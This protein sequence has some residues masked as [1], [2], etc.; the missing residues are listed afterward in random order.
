MET[1]TLTYTHLVAALEEF[2]VAARNAY[3]DELI[4]GNKIASGRLLNS[5]EVSVEQ[6]GY[7]YDVVLHLEDYWKWVEEGRPP[8][9]LPPVSKILEWV[10][11]KPVLPKPSMTGRIP[12]PQSLA[13]A[14]SKSI[15]NK[16]VEPFPALARTVPA[17]VDQFSQKLAE[18]FAQDVADASALMIK[19]FFGQG[20]K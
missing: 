7:R 10:L 14:I 9:K 1:N 11:V 2:G 6:H 15:A 8:G 5:V 16:G 13:W 18:A 19:S 20:K 3:Q 4:R 17:T 12:T